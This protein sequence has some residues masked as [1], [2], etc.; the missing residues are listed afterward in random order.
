MA[1]TYEFQNFILTILLLIQLP[2]NT[3]G[4]ATE[5][6]PTAWAPATHFVDPDKTPASWFTQAT[7]GRSL[8]IYVSLTPL[9]CN[10]AHQVNSFVFFL[11]R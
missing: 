8:Y 6:G 5:D 11:N 4:K 3:R 2:T 7:H 10:Y 9:L 1:I